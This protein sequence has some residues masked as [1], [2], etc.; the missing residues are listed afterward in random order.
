VDVDNGLVQDGLG[1]THFG[2]ETHFQADGGEDEFAK[3][4]ALAQLAALV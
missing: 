4:V 2:A 1:R 3:K